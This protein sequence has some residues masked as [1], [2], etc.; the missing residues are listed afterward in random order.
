MAR[1]QRDPQEIAAKRI[2]FEVELSTKR[3]EAT[4]AR[5]ASDKLMEKM[6]STRDRLV[7][8][9]HE[10]AGKDYLDEKREELR[11]LVEAVRDSTAKQAKIA[12]ELGR[13]EHT[14][15]QES[16]VEVDS[17]LDIDGEF[18]N[19]VAWDD[20][21]PNEETTFE[22]PLNFGQMNLA[23]LQLRVDASGTKI[24]RMDEK[25]DTISSETADV[26]AQVEN[27][28]RE[29][30][31]QANELKAL[32]AKVEAAHEESRKENRML[33]EELRKVR[34]SLSELT[35]KLQHQ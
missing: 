24:D 8:S 22:E 32:N 33:L 28:T 2:R 18:E 12:V 9:E 25:L 5:K 6:F 21:Y 16:D 15:Y 4:A 35:A 11:K 3:V 26:R 14:G 23:D 29:L 31:E 1:K 10:G 13:M 19:S 27:A 30:R 17:E 20:D 34:E 7:I